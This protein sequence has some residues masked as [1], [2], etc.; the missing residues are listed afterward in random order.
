MR[1]PT[2]RHFILQ[3]RVLT[4]YRQAVRA[5][6]YIPDS[7][8]RKE[9]VAWIR[10]EFERNRG[11]DDVH[12]IEEKLASGRRELKQILPFLPPPVPRRP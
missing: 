9:T 2:L 1:N 6:R 10:G 11:L 7:N 3:Q 8:A 12:A 5:T 4:L